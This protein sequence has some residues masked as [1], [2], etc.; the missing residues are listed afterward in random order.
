VYS[1]E[2]SGYQTPGAKTIT[3]YAGSTVTFYHTRN[4]AAVTV[5]EYIENEN[6]YNA[7]Y[8]TS[9]TTTEYTIGSTQSVT[10][11]SISGYETPNAQGITV[12]LGSTISFYHKKLVQGYI[13]KTTYHGYTYYLFDCMDWDAAVNKTNSIHG[14]MYD[15]S[16]SGT[17]NYITNWTY[18]YCTVLGDGVWVDGIKTDYA[19]NGIYSQPT[20]YDVWCKASSYDAGFNASDEEMYYQNWAPGQPDNPDSEKYI[21][22]W[23]NQNAPYIGH[24]NSFVPNNSS[25][26]WAIQRSPHLVVQYKN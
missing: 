11:I 21:E 8:Y 6:G 3:V 18:P 20:E 5:K 2:I 15:P 24:W 1:Q 4:T 9:W 26:P 19:G 16:D 7:T 14:H 25:L 17:D 13:A 23:V 12:K 22:L 10:P